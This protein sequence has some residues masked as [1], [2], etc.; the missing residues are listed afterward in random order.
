MSSDIWL[1]GFGT[2][3]NKESFLETV[4][5]FNKSNQTTIPV[6][7]KEFR[8]VFNVCPK[9]YKPSFK[10]SNDPIEIAAMN[11]EKYH[12]SSI[13]GLAYRIQEHELKVL[14]KRELYYDRITV[15]LMDFRSK[16]NIGKGYA[17]IAPSNSK[18]INNSSAEKL[19]PRWEDVVLAR[20][21]AYSVNKKFGEFFDKTT[22]L[23][24]RK[25]LVCN[26]YNLSQL[27]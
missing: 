17:Y 24:D 11:I 22:F 3:I 15:P 14:D 18:W 13:N 2:L 8:R 12:K 10:W 27:D 20:E 16:K 9:H 26:Y 23:A 25:T 4:P 7:I 21:G 19:L 1:L 5:N 6:L